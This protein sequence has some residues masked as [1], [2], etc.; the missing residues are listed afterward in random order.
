MITPIIPHYGPTELLVPCLRSLQREIPMNPPIIGDDTGELIE[1]DLPAGFRVVAGPKTSFAANANRLAKEVKTEWI[2]LMNNDV[3]LHKGYG[4]SL[5]RHLPRTPKKT[6]MVASVVWRANG[7]L[8]S[9]GDVF[10]WPLARPVKR[11]HNHHQITGLWNWP[12]TSVSGALMIVRKSVWDELGGLDES[13]GQY[14]EDVDFG[15]RLMANGYRIG[16]QTDFNATHLEAG[17]FTKPS[18]G[19]FGARNNIW[20]L[21]RHLPNHDLELRAAKMWRLKAYFSPPAVRE[22]IER[23]V[24]EGLAKPVPPAHTL[25]GAR[26]HLIYREPGPLD[27][28]VMALLV[29]LHRDAWG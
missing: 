1:E 15:W 4:R 28:M 6:G 16:W 22:A 17:S 26:R 11:G 21:R 27:N 23:G 5:K 12:I 25:K 20:L 8:D 24:K 14:Y 2:L 29:A 7:R 19:Y 3:R 18:R 13:F 9:F 10:C